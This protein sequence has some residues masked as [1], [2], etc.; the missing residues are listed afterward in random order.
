LNDKFHYN[1]IDIFL[2]NKTTT[3]DMNNLMNVR[4]SSV[5]FCH[6]FWFVMKMQ[7]FI[8]MLFW[9]NKYV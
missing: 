3:K 6:L 5:G 4:L 7:H 2:H 8:D 9:C 1:K